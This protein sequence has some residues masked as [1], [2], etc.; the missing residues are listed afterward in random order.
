MSDL[1]DRVREDHPQDNVTMEALERVF[2]RFR[3]NMKPKA[4]DKARKALEADAA[5]LETWRWGG[6]E[7]PANVTPLHGLRGSER[8]AEIERQR[9]A[10][11]EQ[12][13]VIRTLIGRAF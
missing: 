6:R 8:Q 10:R 2:F 11:A 12:A 7:L 1:K 5:H 4:R 9:L 3:D 13:A